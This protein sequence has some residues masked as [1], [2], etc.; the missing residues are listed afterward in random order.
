M[1]HTQH[2]IRKVDHLVVN[3]ENNLGLP[4]NKKNVTFSWKHPDQK[5]KVELSA[6][7]NNWSRIPLKLENKPAE[8]ATHYQYSTSVSLAPGKYE[9]KYVVNDE[10]RTDATN[11]IE[12]D[13][14]GNV[15]NV[16]YISSPFSMPEKHVDSPLERALKSVDNIIFDLENNLGLS[17]EF[18]KE[19]SSLEHLAMSPSAPQH[20]SSSGSAS[21]AAPAAPAAPA[22]SSDSSTVDAS[23]FSSAKI[24]VVKI[25]SAKKHPKSNKLVVCQ[26]QTDAAG[27][28]VT[29]CAGIQAYYK[30]EELQ[31][32][33]AVAIL[34]IPP[35]PLGG[36]PSQGML[37]AGDNGKFTPN[38]LQVILLQPPQGS[39]V[40]DLVYMKGSQPTSSYPEKIDPNDWF[41]IVDHLSVI[42]GNATFLN[43]D[44]VTE[45]GVV[46]VPGL[47]DGSGIH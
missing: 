22:S 25:T 45:K 7:F 16:M 30:L 17:H 4:H 10:W 20:G 19:K 33:L 23:L 15:N 46:T 40:G 27:S 18:V 11:H 39:N 32:R 47:Q 44:L 8:E 13:V 42:G 41:K 12:K 29:V 43:V 2:A 9:Y 21:G 31:D 14:S 28:S 5:A 6:S 38:Q 24:Q 26:L 34:N 36:V 3:I 1:S 35:R 37:L